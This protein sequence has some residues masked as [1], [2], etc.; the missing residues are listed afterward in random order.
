LGL[1]LTLAA[2]PAQAQNADPFFF[3]DAAALSG[4]AVVASGRDS[5]ALWYN[6]AGFGGLARSSLSASAST[7]GLRIR[8]NPGALRVRVGGDEI[9]SDLSSADVVSV[10]NALVVAARLGDGWSIAGGLLITDRV[11]R[12]GVIDEPERRVTT[13]TGSPVAVSQRLDL[14]EDA[15]S[16]HAGGAVGHALSS[17]VRLGASVF[18]TYRKVSESASYAFFFRD[19]AT[20]PNEARGFAVTTT[21]FGA[22]AIGATGALGV[23]LAPRGPISVGV[24]LRLP[25]LLLHSDVEGA[26]VVASAAGPG[27]GTVSSEVTYPGAIRAGGRV[28]TPARLLGGVAYAL[29]LPESYVEVGLDAAHGLPASDIASARPVVVNARA[30]ARVQIVPKWVVGGGVFSDRAT[31]RSAAGAAGG[32]RIDYYGLTLGVGKRTPL[33]LADDPSPE[34]L[35][36]VTTLSL[37]AAVG[38]GESRASILGA[39]DVG[40]VI[41]DVLFYDFMPYLGSS[42]AF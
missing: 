22:T 32:E 36:L 17:A 24:S 12:A 33:S 20:P 21:R 34:A 1:A 41:E 38:F 3:G 8:K 27:A 42:I 26:T 6:P 40:P 19:A 2:G 31:V 16:Y 10:P 25:E 11:V 7:F 23:Q 39:D 9:V 5:G 37:R 29:G 18:V 30:G 35:V 28:V 15:T 13:S 4:G 14:Q